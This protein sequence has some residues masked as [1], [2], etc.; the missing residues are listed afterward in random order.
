MRFGPADWTQPSDWEIGVIGDMC[1]F[2]LVALDPA[3]SMCKRDVLLG[4]L[5]F[6]FPCNVLAIASEALYLE[7]AAGRTDKMHSS[8]DCYVPGLL[9][10]SPGSTMCYCPS[11][12]LRFPLGITQQHLPGGVFCFA[13]PSVSGHQQPKRVCMCTRRQREA[14][15]KT[16]VLAWPGM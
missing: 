2:R 1:G 10:F 12:A 15:G 8:H 6:F 3:Q 5:F 9:D 14:Q 13:G 4:I 11:P 16:R 7:C